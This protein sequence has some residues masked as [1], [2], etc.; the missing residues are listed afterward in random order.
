[1]APFASAGGPERGEDGPTAVRE[2]KGANI[3]ILG[4]EE[5]DGERVGE[6]AVVAYGSQVVPER[7][8]PTRR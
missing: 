3:R 2:R 5:I 8:G 1:M 6:R 7:G 4:E